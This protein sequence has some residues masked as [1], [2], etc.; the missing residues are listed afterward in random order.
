MRRFC[1]L[2]LT[3]MK[4]SEKDADFDGESEKFCQNFARGCPPMGT[5]T[6][7]FKLIFQSE[8]SRVKD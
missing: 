4:L 3:V 1:P 5:P 2:Y 6:Q 8:N 7:R